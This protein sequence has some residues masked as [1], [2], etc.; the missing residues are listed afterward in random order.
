MT[1]A[2]KVQRARENATAAKRV[3]KSIAERVLSATGTT[4]ADMT[5]LDGTQAWALIRERPTELPSRVVGAALYKAMADL[6]AYCNAVMNAASQ[7]ARTNNDAMAQSALN[8][9]ANI[10][11][12]TAFIERVL[13][14]VGV[15]S[16]GLDASLRGGLGAAWFAVLGYAVAGA[17]V[18]YA[19]FQIIDKLDGVDTEAHA[20]AREAC[21]EQAAATGRPCNDEDFRRYFAEERERER[22]QDPFEHVGKGIGDALF[23]LL[24]IGGVGVGLY[25]A[26]P[27]LTA[28]AV[29]TETQYRAM[30]AKARG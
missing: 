28:K 27:Y 30:R 8:T 13:D 17:A 7:A 11:D 15:S 4:H 5:P 2:Q 19:V 6:D 20:L 29:D 21:N 10:A 26:A 12:A 23:W 14:E 9:S 24:L 25:Y 1:V 3:A 18:I 16:A 22:A